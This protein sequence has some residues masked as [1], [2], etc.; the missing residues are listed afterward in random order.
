MRVLSVERTLRVERPF[1]KRIHFH[2]FFYV[3]NI[4]DAFGNRFLER[5]EVIALFNQFANRLFAF[6][7]A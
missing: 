7:R 1:Y 6:F 3:A 5:N 4:R 2:L